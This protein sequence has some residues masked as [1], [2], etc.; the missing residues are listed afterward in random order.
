MVIIP[1]GKQGVKKK[2]LEQPARKNY[3]KAWYGYHSSGQIGSKKK[4]LEEPARK[5]YSAKEFMHEQ[6]SQISGQ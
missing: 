5:N 3:S 4:S 2:S 6:F 1:V